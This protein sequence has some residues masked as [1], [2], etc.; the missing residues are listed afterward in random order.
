MEVCPASGD[1][2]C[3]VEDADKAYRLREQSDGTYAILTAIADGMVDPSP[4]P[5]DDRGHL[6]VSASGTLFSFR[7]VGNAFLPYDDP[8]F[9]AELDVPAPFFVDRSRTNYDPAEHDTPGWNTN[10][11]ADELEDLGISVMDCP[12]D[13]DADGVVGLSDLLA[14]L[15]NWGS[16]SPLHDVAPAG[17]DGTIDLNDLL[18]ILANWG[19]CT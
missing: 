17:G 19:D 13:F 9:D 15:A 2:W 10:I 7:P 8:W 16:D 11:L 4:S 14:I 12:G 5:C 18:V 1:L 6:W 3:L